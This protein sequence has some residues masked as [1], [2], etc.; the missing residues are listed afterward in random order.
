MSIFKNRM[1]AKYKKVFDNDDG[2]TVLADLMRRAG[3]VGKVATTK[4]MSKGE[5]AFWEGKR[6]CVLEIIQQLDV[7]ESEMV[8]LYVKGQDNGQ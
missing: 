8:N 5:L 1:A 6:A 2:Q 4:K 3:M 7:N